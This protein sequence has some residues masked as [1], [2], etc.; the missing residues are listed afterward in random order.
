MNATLV[1]ALIRQRLASPLRLALVLLFVLPGIGMATITRSLEPL[2]DS[3]YWLALVLAAGAIGQ[4][5]SSG[6][7]HLTFA[8]PVPRPVYVLSR[9]AGAALGGLA[10]AL[11]QL[12][13][14]L[15]FMAGRGSL[16]PVTVVIAMA[17]QHAL[18]AATA[19]AVMLACSSL[20]DGLGDV[21]LFAMGAFA[22]QVG[23]LAARFKG[24]T[25]VVN[26]I[27]AVQGALRPEIGVAWIA[28]HGA[29]P[30]NG[31]VAALSTTVLALV[32]AIVRVRGR[33]L[34]YAAG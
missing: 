17:A 3:A 4:D 19:A 11:L 33:E 32:V 24:W 22:L 12:L 31:V 26:V 34:S 9:W 13:A 2:Q 10:L 30:W 28:A 25:T 1:S 15:V 8:R 27:E 20:A 16:P 5:V 7:L 14:A 29:P 23:Q 6:V 18:L 21:A